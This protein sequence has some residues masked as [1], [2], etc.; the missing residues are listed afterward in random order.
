MTL[1]HESL[2]LAVLLLMPGC[3]AARAGGPPLKVLFIG[4]SYT[5]VNNLPSLVAALAE[6]GGRTIEVE[7]HLVG[8][9]TLE[10]HVHDKRAIE[11]IRA[12]KWDVVILQ[13][14]SLQPILNPEAMRKHARILQEEIARQGA[15]TV[16]YLTWARQ[17]IPQM[18]EGADPAASPGAARQVYQMIQA[19]KVVDFDRW[20][21][22]HRS[23]LAAGLDGA[24]FSTARE[25]GAAVAPV[26]PAWKKAMAAHPDLAL[27]QTD[28]S[29]PTATGSYLAAC[30]FYATLF[31]QSPVG[32]P[33]ELKKGGR[34]LVRIGR[35]EAKMLQEIAW[36]TVQEQKKRHGTRV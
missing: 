31:D 17:H 26:G 29:H 15:K 25:L 16:F 13:E 3:A 32:L 4:N 33:G 8:G 10:Q 14:H 27:H 34:V 12:K 1:H 6:A 19:D 7:E 28:K 36:E 9:C 24:Y 20:S 23:G 21:K 5:S 18:Q 11:K 22:Q 30:V 35:D 2:L